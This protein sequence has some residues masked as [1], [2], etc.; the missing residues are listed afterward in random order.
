[1]AGGASAIVGGLLGL[2]LTDH[3]FRIYRFVR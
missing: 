2:M 1:M 3:V